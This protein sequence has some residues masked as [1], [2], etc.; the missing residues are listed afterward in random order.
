MEALILRRAGHRKAWERAAAGD[1]FAQVGGFL[2]WTVLMSAVGHAS[3][4]G[5]VP[6]TP[7]GVFAAL[8]ALLHWRWEAQVPR[9]LREQ[10]R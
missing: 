2:V 7:L 9:R 6:W 10:E 8:A 1:L 5:L 3:A 4:L